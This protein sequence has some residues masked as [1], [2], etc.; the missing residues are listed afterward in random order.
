MLILNEKNFA[1]ELKKHPQVLVFFYREKGCS[2]CDK[3]KPIFDEHNAPYVKAKYELGPTPDS[4]TGGLIER[5]P[6][7]V[8]YAYGELVGK[9][10]GVLTGEQLDNTFDPEKLQPKQLAVK[11]A[12]L[13][14]LMS[15]E[16]KLIDQI[17]VLK[18][19]L[20]EIQEEIAM[21]RGLVNG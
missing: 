1:Q 5:F 8:A 14:I 4:V 21:R 10:E 20:K 9:Q 13:H 15:D 18:R 17:Y 3:M 6:T 7:F 2:F 19:G 11:E 16:L 12:P